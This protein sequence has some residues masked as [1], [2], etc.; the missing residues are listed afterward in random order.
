MSLLLLV[1]GLILAPTAE[2]IQVINSADTVI[3]NAARIKCSTGLTCTMVGN[4]L[5]IVAASPSFTLES[6]EVLNN[7][8]DDTVE[9]LSNDEAI[10][11][12]LTGFEGKDAQIELAADQ[13]DDSG[14][15]FFIKAEI[16]D[17][18]SIL[19][20]TTTL[21]A[22]SAAGDWS[23]LGTTPYLTVGDGGAED[24]GIVLDGSTFDY[25]FSYDHSA[26]YVVIGKGSAAGTTDA[27]R[28][29]TNQNTIIVKELQ[30]LG[31]SSAYG[32]LNNQVTA[33]ATTLTAVQCGST[34]I[35]SGAVEVELPEA[36]TVVGCRYT[37]VTANASN[38]DIDPDGGDQI[39]VLTNAAG[40]AIRNATLGN[41]VTIQAI[42][43]TSWAVINKEQ[44]TWS[45][46]N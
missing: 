24:T 12:K 22:L 39:L 14:D 43:A 15:S 29:D 10:N 6:A 46:I 42:N 21:S 5:N 18:L 41:S 26:G 3:G 1:A 38:F 17:V 8:V 19:N 2:A 40:D 32:F 37:F 4:K 23:F 11:F 9:I 30:G 45:D 20:E 33:T 7:T 35:N 36:S 44:G 27:V 34:F 16:T 28:W 13:S 31:T 25:N